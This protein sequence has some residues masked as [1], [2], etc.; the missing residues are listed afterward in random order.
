[1]LVRNQEY[2][3]Q[4]SHHAQKYSSAPNAWDTTVIFQASHSLQTKLYVFEKQESH[5][6]QCISAANA[7]CYKKEGIL[8]PQTFERSRLIRCCFLF[9]SYCQ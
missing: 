5:K 4:S 7:S 6:V 8:Q 9:Y 3:V 1:M 2:S